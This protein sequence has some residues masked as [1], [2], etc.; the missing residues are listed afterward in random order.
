MKLKDAKKLHN[1]DEVI[2][3]TT[4]ESVRVLSA[5]LDDHS[6]PQDAVIIEGI[7]ERQG[8]AEWHHRMV[9]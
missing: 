7:G 5:F 8:Y 9:R 4:G 6:Y 2:D 3:K 1:G